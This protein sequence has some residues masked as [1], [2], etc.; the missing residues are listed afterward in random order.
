MLFFFR[1][2]WFHISFFFFE[3]HGEHLLRCVALRATEGVCAGEDILSQ[4]LLEYLTALAVTSK[5]A[6]GF[7]ELDVIEELA[8][9]YS[10]LA[11]EQLKEVAGG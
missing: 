7:P 5:D 3:Q 10:Y 2:S 9:A 8:A 4:Q 11:Y 6:T 1:D